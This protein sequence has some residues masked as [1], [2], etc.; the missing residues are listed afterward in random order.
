M[1]KCLVLIGLLIV[2]VLIFDSLAFGAKTEL[3]L[4]MFSLTPETQKWMQEELVPQFEKKFPDYTVRVQ[5]VPYEG[6]REK[7]GTAL[8]AKTLPDIFEEGTQSA[9]WMASSGTVIPVDKWVKNWTEVKDFYPAAW[10]QPQYQGRQWGIP[11]YMHPSTLLYWKDVFK[12]V[13]LDPNKPPY[14]QEIYLRYIPKLQKIEGNRTV[15]LGGWAPEG[16]RALFQ[17]FEVVIQRF[18][19]K[20]VSEDYS[21]VLFDSEEGEKALTY[22]VKLYQ[23]AYP[24]G[25]AKLP[26]QTP[27][28]WFA[29]KA[30]AMHFRAHTTE[31][32]NVL[33]YNP[34]AFKDLGFGIP[35]RA[36]GYTR[37]VSIQWRNSLFISVN[38]KN[39]DIAIEFIK[40]FVSPKNNVKY[41]DLQGYVPVRKSALS[42]KSVQESPYMGKFMTLAG[43]YGHDVVSPPS[44]F[45]LRQKA[46]IFF[47]EASL[48]KRTVK[49]ALE[50]A[51][52]VWREQLPKE[53]K[54]IIPPGY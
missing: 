39:P 33:R 51:A 45:E 28:P 19:G 12:E 18:G 8:S 54:P 3:T 4:W 40:L 43:P 35:L 11:F 34:E 20:L 27:I 1:K 5:Y 26:E 30:I 22:L 42:L 47:E 38:C 16:W 9:G 50:E 29:Q 23:T 6:Y 2:Y 49:S 14:T 25:V 36:E 31:V 52:K 41:C 7:I 48:G 53:P 24:P 13:G 21:K 17:E 15:R 32:K 44:Y 10:K 37:K 46:G